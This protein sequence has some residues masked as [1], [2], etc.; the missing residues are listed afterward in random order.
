MDGSMGGWVGG[1]TAPP[2]PTASLTFFQTPPVTPTQVPGDPPLSLVCVFALPQDRRPETDGTAFWPL[3]DRFVDFGPVH[4]SSSHAE[5]SPAAS[6]PTGVFPLDD[7]RNRRFKLIP[8]IVDGP[9]MIKWAVGN[10]PTIL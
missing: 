5:G 4:S 9:S 2:P 6:S 7:V 3:F 10:K 1:C 8:A